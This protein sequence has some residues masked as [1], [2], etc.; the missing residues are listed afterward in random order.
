MVTNSGGAI[1]LLNYLGFLL[2]TFRSHLAILSVRK[3]VNARIL[4]LPA[5]RRIERE[6][7]RIFREHD[8]DDFRRRTPQLGYGATSTDTYIELV[9]FGMVDV[10]KTIK[11]IVT[12]IAQR[13]TARGNGVGHAV[14]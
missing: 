3:A 5:Y 8:S 7:C 10:D 14:L 6:L 9:K 1:A 2:K 11:R 4:Y 12:S 13:N